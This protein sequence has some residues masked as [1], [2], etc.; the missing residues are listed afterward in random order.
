MVQPGHT[1]IIRQWAD[2]ASEYS[3]KIAEQTS[4]PVGLR[5]HVGGDQHNGG[6]WGEPES[7]GRILT[8]PAG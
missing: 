2:A 3:L 5:K 7:T 8:F 6:E 1:P 4:A